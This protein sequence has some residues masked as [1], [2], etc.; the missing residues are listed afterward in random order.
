LVVLIYKSP[1]ATQHSL[2][3]CVDHLAALSTWAIRFDVN[4]ACYAP[5]STSQGATTR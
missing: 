1:V 5:L 3:N 2:R 4:L